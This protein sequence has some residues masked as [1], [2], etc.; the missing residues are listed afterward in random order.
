MTLSFKN[1]EN[2]VLTLLLLIYAILLL[3][4]INEIYIFIG[5]E[6]TYGSSVTSLINGVIDRNNHPLLAK[7]IWAFFV[8]LFQVT[9]GTDKAIFWRL[10]TVIL[11]VGTLF[12]FYKISRLFFPRATSFIAMGILA[13]DPMY[14]SFSRLLQLDIIMLFFSLFSLYYLLQYFRK[15]ATKHLLLAGLL[16]G[17]SISVKMSSILMILAIVYMIIF[18]PPKNINYSFIFKILSGFIV[19]VIGGYF[20]GNIL[21]FI[22]PTQINIFSYTQSLIVSQLNNEVVGIGYMQSPAWSWFTIPQILPLY[23]VEFE[24]FVTTIVSFQNPLFFISTLVSVLLTFILI[25]KGKIKN[26][27][28]YKIILLYFLAHYVP[29]LSSFHATYY[30]YIIPLLPVIILMLINLIHL[31]KNPKRYLYLFFGFSILI[32]GIYYP[33]LVG[34]NISKSY[35]TKLKSYSQYHFPSKN[36]LLCQNCSPG[37]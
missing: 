19:S 21:F 12:L 32:F 6:P 20:L 23:R 3:V 36:T 11:S 1:K 33:L 26:L 2:F 29:W 22:L 14:F 18:H 24:N 28:S 16:L 31:T 7:S 9:T 25:L 5:D 4:N 37:K 30:Y 15:F 8:F 35:E 10:G 13:L 17:L 27:L 34:L